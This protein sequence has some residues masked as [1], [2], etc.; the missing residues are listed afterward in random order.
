MR[1]ALIPTAV[2]SFILLA[3]CEDQAQDSRPKETGPGIHQFEMKRI[4]G[5]AQ[6][7]SDYKGKVVLVVNVASECG[8]T[9]QYEGLQKLYEKYSDRGFTVLGF[10]C[11]DF[12]A[13]E[14]GSDDSISEFCS[15]T[16][17]VKFPLF[18]KVAVAG[19]APCPLYKYLQQD[20]PLKS[21][22]KWN[23]HKF[24]IDGDGH[25]IA[26]FGSKVA[27]ADPK[28]TSAIEGALGAAPAPAS[29]PVG[30]P[31]PAKVEAKPTES[32]P[33]GKTSGH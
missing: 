8:F 29:K 11:N 31:A 16:Y 18:S 30:K 2:L 20:C 14:P 6:K 7:L 3:A 27:P 17:G 28:L 24:L 32:K 1:V 13:Q 10:P 26:A 33:A 12:G 25:V 5:K 19:A 23:F 9:P 4:D 21:T 22:V 15:Q